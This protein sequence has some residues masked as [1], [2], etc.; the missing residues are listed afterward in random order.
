MVTGKENTDN[1]MHTDFTVLVNDFN[2]CEKW[3][4]KIPLKA[5]L[6]FSS[7][8]LGTLP[9]LDLDVLSFCQQIHL[10]CQSKHTVH[11]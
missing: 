2:L 8:G 11:E 5:H 4:F 9:V 3:L 10:D 7:F 6:S 1:I